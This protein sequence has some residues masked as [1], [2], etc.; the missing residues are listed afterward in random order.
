MPENNR[1]LR[2]FLCHTSQDK[3]V[4]RELYQ[5]LLAEG[6]IDP[7][8]DKEKI[9]PGQEWELEI[10]ESVEAADV[11]IICVSKSSV[12][13]EGYYQKEIKK[14]LD[15]AEEKPEGT[16]FI[17][18]LRLD[19]CQIPR[20]L[21]KW[22][23][24]DYF[25]PK[26]RE[27]AYGRL[28]QSLHTRFDQVVLRKNIHQQTNSSLSSPSTSDEKW[29][30]KHRLDAQDGMKRNGFVGFVEVQFSLPDQSLNVLQNNL[31]IGA[32]KAQIHTFG[33]P[34]GIV[35]DNPNSSPM[36][37]SDGIKAEIE[38]RMD[39]S[40]RSI[41]SYDYWSLSNSGDFYLMKSLFEDGELRWKRGTI[42]AFDTRIQRTTEILLYCQRLYEFL[43]VDLS[44]IIRVAIRHGGLK[45]RYLSS[46]KHRY[47][48]R[49][50]LRCLE[51]ETE[52]T[53]QVALRDIKSNLVNLVKEFTQPIFV[54]FEFQEFADSLYE[55]IVNSYAEGKVA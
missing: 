3:P 34:I 7:W 37:Q 25:P 26:Q 40:G 44:S 30:E 36:P 14:I 28:L 29:L 5:R 22:Q 31:L 17:I 46:T 32:R 16:I 20:R 45:D 54:L 55:D 42:I 48:S 52:G 33:W 18:P 19:D 9:L 51:T 8:L 1:K 50:N 21:S 27:Q 6:W 47:L 35:L 2:V 39:E 23:Y 38:F 4:V 53:V 13:K 41:S 15:V 24:E 11:V 12:G 49:Q 43:G 10:E